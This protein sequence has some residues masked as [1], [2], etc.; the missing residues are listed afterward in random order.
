MPHSDWVP[1]T[2][3]VCGRSLPFWAA[4]ATGEGA[5]TWT[6]PIAW[7]GSVQCGPCADERKG[8][9]VHKSARLVIEQLTKSVLEEK[10]R[11]RDA[12]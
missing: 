6:D 9:H 3:E 4:T 12:H 2:C 1:V 5:S 10:E 7:E 8:R 11:T